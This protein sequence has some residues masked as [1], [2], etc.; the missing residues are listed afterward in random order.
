MIYLLWIISLVSLLA[1]G[2]FYQVGNPEAG[3]TEAATRDEVAR[4]RVQVDVLSADLLRNQRDLKNAQKDLL[5]LSTDYQHA[6]DEIKR[7]Q[8]RP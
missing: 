7:M 8:A 1:F 5:Q 2:Y 6:V 4:Y 3:R